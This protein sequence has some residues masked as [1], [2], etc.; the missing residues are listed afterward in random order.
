MICVLH[1]LRV[2]PW[3][4]SVWHGVKTDLGSFLPLSFVAVSNLTIFE[5]D[6]LYLFL[7][8]TVY[9]RHDSI[10]HLRSLVPIRDRNL[11]R[12]CS[13]RHCRLCTR[14]AKY[15]RQPESRHLTSG[16]YL[17]WAPR[18]D[19][20][21]ACRRKYMHPN[22]SFSQPQPVT[23]KC[24]VRGGDVQELYELATN[25]T[26]TTVSSWSCSRRAIGSR[27]ATTKFK[28]I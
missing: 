8:F 19:V 18:T 17:P 25:T 20:P 9:V 26:C 6:C 5:D 7:K 22:K 3:G 24:S 4:G 13:H 2:K 16:K 10:H 12:L 23:T 27:T 15:E 21:A 28:T 14:S 1:G 11:L